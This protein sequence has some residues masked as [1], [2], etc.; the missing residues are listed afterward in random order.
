MSKHLITQTLSVVVP[1]YNDQ[2]VV[3]ELCS[4]L[5]SVLNAN[6]ANFEIIFIDDCS[7]DNTWEKLK[8]NTKDFKN[9]VLLQLH[10]NVGQQN[11][12]SAGLDIS[13]GEIIV[14]MDSDLQ[15]RPEDIPTLVNSLLL[16]PDSYMAISRWISRDDSLIKKTLSKLFNKFTL[17]IT[18]IK[19]HENLGVFRALKREVLVEF[20]KYNEKTAPPLSLI[21]WIGFNYIPVDLIRDKRF[22]GKT[23]YSIKKMFSL[24]MS[25][26]FSYS[27]FP[28]RLAIYS[29]V[30]VACL[31]FIGAI[32]LIFQKVYGNVVPGWTSIITLILFLF[33]MNFIF[34]GIIG[35]YLGRIF[36]ESKNR[37]R[38]HINRK[39]ILE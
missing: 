32:F 26:I 11:A 17:R 28:I 39:I 27:M 7:K 34:L 6:F 35:E 13:K 23:G 33:G 14:I 25:R 31:S 20:A 2:E 29:G 5:K 21:Y 10:K 9:T 37:P 12:L 16:N 36:L 3:E 19:H 30:A 18:G 1:F 22:A 15:D 4:R 8:Q 38:Y 24:A